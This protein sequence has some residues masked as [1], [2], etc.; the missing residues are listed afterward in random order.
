MGGE[1]RQR[2]EEK[3]KRICYLPDKSGTRTRAKARS[4]PR[5]KVRNSKIEKR[6]L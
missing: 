4:L 3:V 5:R 6:D 1:W 2:E